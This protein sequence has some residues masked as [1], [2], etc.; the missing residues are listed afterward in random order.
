MTDRVLSL[1]SLSKDPVL[2]L[3]HPVRSGRLLANYPARKV[4]HPLQVAAFV[5]RH[6]ELGSV[7]NE[8][9]AKRLTYLAPKGLVDLAESVLDAERR[10]LVG[11]VVEAGTALGGSAIV[12]AR[13]KNPGR[14]MWIFDAFG[15]IPVPTDKDNAESHR[16]YAEIAAGESTGI[17]SGDLYYGY[18]DDLLGEVMQ[19][20]AEFGLAS[21]ANN[22]TFVKGYYEETLRVEFPIVLAHLDCD[23]YESVMVCLRQI[24]PYLVPG[25]RFVVDD[26]NSWA[27][28]TAAVDEFF[29]GRSDYEFVQKS[30]L[31]I[32]KR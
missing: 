19:S 31:H 16:R 27:G 11:A 18:R 4:V 32:V 28:C 2:I 15:M 29:A 8:V 5:R 25:G 10:G 21:D 9:R 13:S 26:Y 1:R 3:K 30:R 6:P 14:P 20:F 22:V 24:D 7:I 23:W 17:S 12:L